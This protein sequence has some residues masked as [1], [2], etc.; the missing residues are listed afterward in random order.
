V[1]STNFQVL[2]RVTQPQFEQYFP[3]DNWKAPNEIPQA[4]T[5]FAGYEGQNWMRACRAQHNGAW[6]PGKEWAGAC[7]I[8]WGGKEI[9]LKQYQVLSLFNAAAGGN[10]NGN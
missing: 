4:A 10:R 3:T 6:H 9:A 2:M 8:G 5:F 1:L 7:N